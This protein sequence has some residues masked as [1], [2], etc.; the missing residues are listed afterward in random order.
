VIGDDAFFAAV[1]HYVE[2]PDFRYGI[3]D[4]D[5]MCASFEESTGI[6]LSWFFD[7]W[8]YHPG[9]PK[10]EVGWSSQEAN[11]GYDVVVAISQVQDVGPI[12]KMPIDLKVVTY[13]GNETFVVWDSLPSQVYDLYVEGQPLAVVLDPERWI[14]RQV[15]PMGVGDHEDRPILC[16]APNHPNP[17]TAETAIKFFLPRPGR[18]GIDV[19]D[20]SG[21]RV[22]RLVEGRLPAGYGSVVWNGTDAR[23]RSVAPG[24]YFCR[25]WTPEGQAGRRMLRIR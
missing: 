12:F 4:T 14:I 1:R 6:E 23:G 9:F 15:Q 25:L 16:L 7:Q 3:A 19:F 20:L 5:D 22:K 17:F 21:R 24:V 2:E 8:I 10:Y 11:G 13:T 18:V